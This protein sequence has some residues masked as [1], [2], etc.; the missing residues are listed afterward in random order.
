MKFLIIGLG[1]IGEEYAHTRH[2]IGF[3]VV[4]ALVEKYNGQFKQERLA[5]VATIKMKGKT[6]ICIKP[7]TFMNLSGK[8]VK[9]WLEKE[10][11]E[12]S[13]SLVI[14]DDLALPL[15]KL[16]LRPSGSDAGH[17][18]LKSIEESLETRDY[19]RLRFGIGN[20]YPKGRQ[21]DF[22]LGKWSVQEQPLVN[23]KIEGS[24]AVIEN[25]ILI[26]L[27]KAMNAINNT[28]ITVL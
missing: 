9:Y 22:V 19:P 11:I 18:G 13:R 10:K 20:E 12:L 27:E 7:S 28:E 3:D 8:A 25:F 24:V 17:N 15:T 14:L 2:N 5:A 26:G 16:R 23:K 21:V 1:N 4:D 6:V